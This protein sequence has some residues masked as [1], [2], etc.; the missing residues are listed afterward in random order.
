MKLIVVGILVDTSLFAGMIKME[1]E[2][3]QKKK[4]K[5]MKKDKDRNNH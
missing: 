4:N 1:I 5:V 2:E 3:H